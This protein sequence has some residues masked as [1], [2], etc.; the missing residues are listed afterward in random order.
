MAE[1][2]RDREQRRTCQHLCK[3]RCCRYVV[4]QIRAPRLKA[5]YDEISWFLAHERVSIYYHH[6]RWHLELRTRCRNLTPNNLCAIYHTRPI[7]CRGYDADSCEYP[8][9]PRHDLQFDT[10]AEFDS[11]WEKKLAQARRK[12]RARAKAAKN[13]SRR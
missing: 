13:R 6:R 7:V 2:D 1:A 5:D 4:V 3:A 12:R 10:K 11:W 8:A 9:R